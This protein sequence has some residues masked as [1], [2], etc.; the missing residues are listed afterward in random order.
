M[1]VRFQDVFQLEVPDWVIDPFCDIISENGI[2]E[3]K[4]KTLKSGLELK[5][6]FKI[7]YQLFWLQSKIKERYF[8]V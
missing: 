7:L 2:L 4:L 8:Q 3:E 1:E 6:K 5:P